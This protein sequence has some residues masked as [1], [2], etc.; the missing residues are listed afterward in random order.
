MAEWSDEERFDTIQR[1][2]ARC[3][4]RLPHHGSAGQVRLD[5]LVALQ[6]CVASAEELTRNAREITNA[7]GNVQEE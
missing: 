2:V 1:I 5:L 3:V 4:E 7:L 6:L